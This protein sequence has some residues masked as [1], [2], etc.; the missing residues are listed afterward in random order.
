MVVGGSLTTALPFAATTPLLPPVGLLAFL[1]WRQ[2]R[3]DLL[4]PWTAIGFGL[5]DDLVSGNPLGTALFLWPL[6]GLALQTSDRWFLF[7]SWRHDWLVT[8]LAGLAY[9]LA[10]WLLAPMHGGG[11]PVAA[12]LLPAALSIALIPL[13]LRLATGPGFRR[14]R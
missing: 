4:P 9:L 3:P 14:R 11:P 12:L 5:F 7:R 8:A 1:L 2:L 6:F 10:L 13:L